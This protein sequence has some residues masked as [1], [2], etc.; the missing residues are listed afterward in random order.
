MG[1]TWPGW[2]CQHI[3]G[4]I[5]TERK[6]EMLVYGGLQAALSPQTGE[7]DRETPWGAGGL[8]GAAW[9]LAPQA[10]DQGAA[11]AWGPGL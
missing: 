9:G 11:A 8:H 5:E 4:G 1:P 10:S 7:V 2:G 3:S 6:R